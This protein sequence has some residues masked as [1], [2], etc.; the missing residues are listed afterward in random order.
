MFIALV[1]MKTGHSCGYGDRLRSQSLHA[2]V[3]EVR[4][5]DWNQ[6]SSFYLDDTPYEFVGYIIIAGALLVPQNRYATK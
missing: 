4:I 2:F 3:F 1:M 6:I 5:D